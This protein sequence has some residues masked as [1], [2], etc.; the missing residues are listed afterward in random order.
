MTSEAKK[1]DMMRMLNV[2][3]SNANILKSHMLDHDQGIERNT[4]GTDNR[5][6]EEKL[7]DRNY[8]TQE[9]RKKVYALFNNDATQSEAYL[10][11]IAD[12]NINGKEF[13]I[14]YPQLVQL[15]KGTL[16]SAD[17][18]AKT[19]GQ[20]IDNFE[21]TGNMNQAEVNSL[22]DAIDEMH[23]WINRAYKSGSIS[24]EEGDKGVD[25]LNHVEELTSNQLVT[26][27]SN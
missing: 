16:A 14:V 3:S 5:T 17:A 12:D 25:V 6:I 26:L 15:F 24:K 23:E 7:N 19:T 11:L 4:T 8:M 18:V 22:T 1:R 2:A 9:M 20:L 13:N 27:K 21:S 10:D